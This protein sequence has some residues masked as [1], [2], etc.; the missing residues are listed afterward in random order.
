[1]SKISPCLW[2]NGSAGDAA[3]AYTS[4]LPNSRIV[5]TT[6][7][8]TG[9]PIPAGEI[10][11]VDFEI[12]GQS[13]QALNGGPEFQVNPSISFFVQLQDEA[14]VRRIATA[15]G[16]GG[17]FLMELGTYAWSGAYAWVQDRF[18]VS[19]QVMLVDKKPATTLVPCLMFAGAQNGRAFSAMEVW[20]SLF[21]S[22]RIDSVERYAEGEGP[23]GT[24]KH[25]RFT[26]AGQPFVAM[27]SH[28]A[29]D[30]G[31]SEGVSLSILCDDQE[32]VDRLWAALCDGGAP[33][34]CGWLQDRFGVSWQIVPRRMVELQDKGD[35]DAN[36]RM[37]QA[38]M[39]MARLDIAALEKAYWGR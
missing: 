8:T 9:L 12:D 24:V 7:A 10:L 17:K 25:G 15:L 34:Q 1:M 30:V 33:S 29:H 18:G 11:L 19:W 31:F 2:F 26:L 38:M 4:L 32:E 5:Q 36:A 21:A 20:T 27:D 35:D 39:P 23:T 28:M 37:F 16:E 13:M 22:S 3:A 6:R 14:E